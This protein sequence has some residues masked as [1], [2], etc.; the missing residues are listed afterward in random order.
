MDKNMENKKCTN[1]LVSK[2]FNEFYNSKR[3]KD[4][5]SYWCTNCICEKSRNYHKENKATILEKAKVYRKNN[6]IR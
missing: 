5:K 1:C 4:G 2:P 6:Y 3:N